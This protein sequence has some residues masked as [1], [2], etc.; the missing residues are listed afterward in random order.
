MS[1]TVEKGDNDKGGKID[2]DYVG[3]VEKEE[4]EEK[5]EEGDFG[6]VGVD[7][8]MKMKVSNSYSN[9]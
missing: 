5:E 7:V 6:G 4:K 1:W 8:E 2:V 3:L 9:W